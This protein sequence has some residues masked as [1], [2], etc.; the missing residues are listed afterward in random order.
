MPLLRLVVVGIGI[1]ELVGEDGELLVRV[2]WYY[3]GP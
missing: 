1:W 2:H 3:P